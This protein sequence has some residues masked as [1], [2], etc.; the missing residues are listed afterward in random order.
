MDDLQVLRELRET[1]PPPTQS[2]LAG[3]R[4][5]L[6]AGMVPPR[7]RPGWRLAVTVGLALALAAG[8]TVADT[9]RSSPSQVAD[10]AVFLRQAAT[11]VDDG[12]SPAERTRPNAWLY[13]KRLTTWPGGEP[14][15]QVERWWRFD[16]RQT[17]TYVPQCGKCPD[18]LLSSP[19]EP[20]GEHGGHGE[21]RT[22]SPQRIWHHHES[23]PRDPALLLGEL[24]RL[25][26]WASFGDL[27]PDQTAD[28]Q[29]FWVARDL[30]GAGGLL[31]PPDLQAALFR[32][33]ARIPGVQVTVDGED[34]AGR[35]AVTIR[36]QPSPK[37]PGHNFEGYEFFVDPET[38]G[39]LGERGQD[40]SGSALL[41][42]ALTDQAGERPQ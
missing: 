35:A 2:G 31:P 41:G 14:D 17:V 15:E 23:L 19:L 26:V 22:L 18:G 42:S 1:V 6:V 20:R 11:V 37:V 16:G 5:R 34:P 3:I 10:A 33:L 30:L 27:D 32:A 13:T 24:R 12:E 38:Y 29:A 39:Y 40:G 9:L 7:R 36:Y 28:S 8:V 4:R 25:G 21:E